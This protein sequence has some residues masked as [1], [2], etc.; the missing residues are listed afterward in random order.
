MI[1]ID[2]SYGEGGGQIVRTACSLAALSGT[3]CRVINVRQRR[4]QPGLMHQHLLAIR[5]LAELCDA[6]LTGASIGSCE[7]VF[8]PRK[9]TSREL[10]IRIATAGSI[11]LILQALI[12]ASLIAPN[13]ITIRF[14]G[15]ATDT[16]MSPT[17]DYFRHVLLWF[18][19]GAGAHVELNLA[20]RGYYPRGGAEISVEIVPARLAAIDVIERGPL[21]AVRIFSHAAR[22][23]KAR[24]VAE[25]QA[26]AALETLGTLALPPEV[27]IDYAPSLSAGSAS[28][29]VAEFANTVVGADA[30]GA[31]G[32]L[33]EQVGKEAAA[34]LMREL[35]TP[36]CLDRHM[37][38]QILP[39]MALAG[40]NGRVRVSEI[41][42]HCRTNMWV[43]EQFLGGSFEVLGDL[44]SWIP[45][46]SA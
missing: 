46:A 29:V 23:L 9:L 7:L 10:T 18:L 22:V 30:L 40:G 12:P 21:R 36:G 6:S 8:E 2:G 16:A 27:N 37:A 24:R 15:G 17:L 42:G 14:E 45:C 19:K 3:P 44:V 1:E 35:A 33:A 26:A 20:R 5:A 4:R 34:G 28:C 39:Y 41:T 25:R 43:I 32:K 31:V 38:D 13:P 11:T